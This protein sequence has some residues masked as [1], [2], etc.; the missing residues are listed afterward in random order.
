MNTSNHQKFGTITLHL[1]IAILCFYGISVCQKSTA[2]CFEIKH[3]DFFGLDKIEKHE[4]AEDELDQL[5]DS[6]N[7][8]SQN[9]TSFLVPIIV[10]QLKEFHPNCNKSPNRK[11]FDKFVKLYFKIRMQNISN[12]KNQNIEEQLVLI[13]D[14]FYSQLNDDK[15][16][17]D[18]IYTM[19]DR[20][21]YGEIP[22]VIP[23][24]KSSQSKDTTF[25]KITL[26]KTK[27]RVVL[28]ATDKQNK[29]IWS[30]I[31]T[32]VNPTRYLLKLDF[33]PNAVEETP[34]A[35]IIHLWT[36][37][38]LTLYLRPDGKFIYYSHSW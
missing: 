3:L 4:W 19:S 20:P 5:L 24:S 16:L 10:W 13:R 6:E 30:R 33:D 2:D 36:S 11:K 35:T 28:V 7:T 27:N 23:K 37:E 34:L 9:R 25:G 15:L 8:I 31:M 17:P 12:G 32:G 14:D 22:K 21:L 29:V 26:I 1:S 18:M 38:R